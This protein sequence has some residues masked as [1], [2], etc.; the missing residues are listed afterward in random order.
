MA[1]PDVGRPR[2]DEN[3]RVDPAVLA[4]LVALIA[5][6]FALGGTWLGTRLAGTSEDRRWLR[7]HRLDAYDEVLEA[8]DAVSIQ[9]DVVHTTE[10]GTQAAVDAQQI[11]LD[12]QAL[13]YRAADRVKLVGSRAIQGPV[14]ALTFYCGNTLATKA[15]TR[16]RSSADE[17]RAARVTDLAPLFRAVRDA[18]RA[19]LEKGTHY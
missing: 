16:P 2:E 1:R 13:A 11:L 12:R 15:M 7:Q 4:L 10:P 17:W 14:E 19:D 3:R 9:A 6:G 18:A 8:C 5:G